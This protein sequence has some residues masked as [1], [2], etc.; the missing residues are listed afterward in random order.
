MI[1]SVYCNYGPRPRF[2]EIAECYDVRTVRWCVRSKASK[3][4]GY[5]T[6]LE[7]IHREENLT[8]SA[9]SL[10][11]SYYGRRTRPTSKDI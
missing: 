11:L 1:F 4:I 2:E 8:S 9:L 7:T 6:T 10:S 5:I 3:S